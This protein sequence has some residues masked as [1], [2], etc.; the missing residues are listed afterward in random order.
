MASRAHWCPFRKGSCTIQ[1]KTDRRLVAVVK[2]A[3]DLATGAALSLRAAGFGVIM[4]ELP[5]PIAIR[6]TV[7][8]AEAIYAG[9]HVVEGARA[10]RA[11]IDGWGAVL[12]AGTV[13]VIVDPEGTVVARADPVVVV[14]AVMAKTN[15]G[16]ARREGAVV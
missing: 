15:V 2:G 6:L 11:S 13:A 5:Q 10:E 1:P 4:T 3:G 9:S 12:E 8:F 7:S 16:T 14:D